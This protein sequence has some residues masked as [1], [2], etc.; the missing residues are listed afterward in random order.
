MAFTIRQ[1]RPGDEKGI[2]D[3][4]IK[5]WQTTYH[6]FV[7]RAFLDSFEAARA[8]RE[9]MWT[10]TISAPEKIL[11]VAEEENQIIG[12][13]AAGLNRDEP[14]VYSGEIYAI[15]VLA[16]KQWSGVGRALFEKGRE[17]LGKAGHVK[18]SLWVLENNPAENFYRRMGGIP[19][20]K[21]EDDFGGNI[22]NE[23]RYGW[24]GAKA[25]EG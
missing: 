8:R 21:K 18:F 2:T 25:N 11:W 10:E 16:E 12:F 19:D 22:L 24:G 15:Y 7:P 23:I 4:H 20:A 1:A 9:K 6:P 17:L 14:R 13:V 3:V 5:T